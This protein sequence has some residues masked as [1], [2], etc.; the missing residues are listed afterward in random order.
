LLDLVRM[1]RCGLR[2]AEGNANLYERPLLHSK[3]G[4]RSFSYAGPAAWFSLPA[5]I[6]VEPDLT[7]FKSRL[8]THLFILAFNLLN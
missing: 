1:V 8:K 3:F 4:E 7:R 6:R 5:A 2:S